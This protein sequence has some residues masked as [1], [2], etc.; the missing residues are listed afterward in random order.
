MKSLKNDHPLKSAFFEDI[1]NGMTRNE[2]LLKKYP[3]HIIDRFYFIAM[4][5][6]HPNKKS[7]MPIYSW[8]KF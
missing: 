6:Y 4:R 7:S 1:K 3:K 5:K 8:K 2:E